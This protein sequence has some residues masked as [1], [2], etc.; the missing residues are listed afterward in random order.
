MYQGEA[1]KLERFTKPFRDLGPEADVTTKDVPYPDLYAL[2]G[3]DEESAP[4]CEKNWNRII[5]SA[6]LNHPHPTAFR[7]VYNVIND[8][9][10]KYGGPLYANTFLVEGYSKQGV[11]AVDDKSTSVP[12]RNDVLLLYVR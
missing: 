9:T 4:V 6:R 12:F 7:R 2:N 3:D 8:V 11:T 1:S 10:R 5:F